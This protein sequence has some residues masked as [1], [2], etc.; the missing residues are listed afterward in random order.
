M[1]IH[2]LSE[3]EK[4]V[5]IVNRK[6]SLNQ[7]LLLDSNEKFKITKHRDGK[8]P[9]VVTISGFLSE[10][11]DNRAGWQNSILK[12]FPDNEWFHL[13]WNTQKNPFRKNVLTNKPVLFEPKP[14]KNNLKWVKLSASLLFSYT[15]FTYLLIN[16]W[17]HLAVRNSKHTG[18]LLAE[19]IMACEHRE[20]ILIGHSLGA[21]VIYNCLEHLKTKNFETNITEAHL[22]GGAVNS[23]ILKWDKTTDTVKNKIY[24]YYSSNDKVLK[25]LYSTIMIDRFPIGLQSINL[26]YFEN[27]DST[28]D[29]LGH[30]EYIP[31]FHILKEKN[32]RRITVSVKRTSNYGVIN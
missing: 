18:K 13:E 5:E 7:L 11:L 2:C 20:F 24:N 1:Y 28:E 10:D 4:I 21:R 32:Q 25:F 8:Y 17:W 22:L 31:N 23:R 14:K 16:N 9:A 26:P 27:I 19:T 29:I 30:T 6:K 15:R 3:Y 12:A